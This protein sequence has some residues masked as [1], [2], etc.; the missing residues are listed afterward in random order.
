MQDQKSIIV[1]WL[2]ALS[3]EKREGMISSLRSA[4]GQNHNDTIEMIL[5]QFAGLLFS[6]C[7][8]DM[9]LSPM[10]LAGLLRDPKK[11]A[12]ASLITV[13]QHAE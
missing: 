1:E 10:E 3:S 13:V 12:L 9:G 8:D 11:E 2:G 6:E 7:A 4:L 5:Q